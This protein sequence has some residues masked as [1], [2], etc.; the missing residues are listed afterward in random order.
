MT[1]R[2][3]RAPPQGT[4]ATRPLELRR[5]QQPQ[6]L[7]APEEMTAGGGATNIEGTF[8]PVT[9]PHERE[10][11]VPASQ[12]PP[13]VQYE[14]PPY[15]PSSPFAVASPENSPQIPPWQPPQPNPHILTDPK[16]PARMTHQPSAPLAAPSN[17]TTR[18]PAATMS[19]APTTLLTR[20]KSTPCDTPQKYVIC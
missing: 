20:Q 17:K 7:S 15:D 6:K 11:D 16:R 1:A 10:Q 12:G 14:A 8:P 5:V 18:L 2:I 19:T 4:F 9:D 3:N 13:A